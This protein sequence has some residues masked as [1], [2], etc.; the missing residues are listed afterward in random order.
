MDFI[1]EIYGRRVYR[2]SINC[3][4]ALWLLTESSCIWLVNIFRSN[5]IH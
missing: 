3:T 1:L 2:A 5:G 4:C